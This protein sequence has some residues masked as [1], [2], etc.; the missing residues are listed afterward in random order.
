M[1]IG[2]DSEG[3]HILCSSVGLRWK[4]I[5]NLSLLSRSMVQFAGMWSPTLTCL[6]AVVYPNAK[7]KERGLA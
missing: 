5:R 6:S 3:P 4:P 7:D 1:G 2:S